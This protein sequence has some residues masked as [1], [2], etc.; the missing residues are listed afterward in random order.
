MA[1]PLPA[2]SVKLISK[3]EKLEIKDWAVRETH[4]LRT[5]ELMWCFH[6]ILHNSSRYPLKNLEPELR[7]F[8]AGGKLLGVDHAWDRQITPSD[9]QTVSIVLDVPNGTVSSVFVVNAKESMFERY[10]WQIILS[11]ILAFILFTLVMLV[12]AIEKLS[13]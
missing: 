12:F 8:G 2:D 1:T 10:L 6:A 5:E 7:Y 4:T 11:G 13:I 3:C 9:D